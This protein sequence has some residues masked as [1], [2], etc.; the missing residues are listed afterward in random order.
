MRITIVAIGA[1][2]LG[3]SLLSAIA[4]RDGHEVSLAFSAAL[5]HDRYNLEIPWLAKYFDDREEVIKAIRETNPEV[6]VFSCLTA[7]YQWM[8]GIAAEAK[9]INPDVK[10]IFGGVHVSAVP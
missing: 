6:L 4:K 10:T 5:F 3:L 9:A 2:Q 8:L 1:E 7:T